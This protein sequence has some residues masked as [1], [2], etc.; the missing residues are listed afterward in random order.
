MKKHQCRN[1]DDPTRL[2]KLKRF[3]CS[4]TFV[5]IVNWLCEMCVSALLRMIKILMYLMLHARN[6]GDIAFTRPVRLL[7]LDGNAG[8][9]ADVWK[10]REDLLHADRVFK[11]HDLHNL[12]L[13][14]AGRERAVSFRTGGGLATST[15]S[16]WRIENGDDVRD[17][18]FDL[19]IIINYLYFL[20]TNLVQRQI[21]IGYI[22]EKWIL[23]FF[24]NVFGN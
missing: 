15:T 4:L 23:I 11:R 8:L 2:K 18:W 14:C 12:L 24:R 9:S 3:Q 6:L 13:G 17:D 5:S 7:D 10:L 19:L 20:K 22:I 21:R 16:S 1:D